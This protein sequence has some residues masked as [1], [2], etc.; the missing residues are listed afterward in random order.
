MFSSLKQS[1]YTSELII[2]K[3]TCLKKIYLTKSS[4]SAI[5]LS[6]TTGEY[7]H[8]ISSNSGKL[9]RLRLPTG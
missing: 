5:A 2:D 6:F 3:P 8:G 9:T 1:D 7:N 4:I